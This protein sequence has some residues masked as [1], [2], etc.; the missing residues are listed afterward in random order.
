M[1]MRDTIQKTNYLG[2]W[3]KDQLY[4]ELTDYGNLVLLSDGEAHSL[5]IME[6]I[7]CWSWC[8]HQ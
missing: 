5:V 1:L 4:K 7:C 6:G 8:S 3:T 2:E